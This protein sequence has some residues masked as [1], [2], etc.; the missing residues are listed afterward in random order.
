MNSLDWFLK[1]GG[2]PANTGIPYMPVGNSYLL[3]ISKDVGTKD[4]YP[5]ISDLI[6][7][8][9]ATSGVRLEELLLG[10]TQALRQI[11]TSVSEGQDERI[12]CICLFVDE[13]SDSISEKL[14]PRPEFEKMSKGEDA[15]AWFIQYLAN[16]SLKSGSQVKIPNLITIDTEVPRFG[17]RSSLTGKPTPD[18]KGLEI[19]HQKLAVLNSK[20]PGSGN[21]ME[22]LKELRNISALNLFNTVPSMSGEPLGAVNVIYLHTLTNLARNLGFEE[23]MRFVRT[24]IQTYVLQDPEDRSTG[25]MDSRT[26][27]QRPGIL[28]ACLDEDIV[29]NAEMRIAE[30]FFDGVITFNRAESSDRSRLEISYEIT[31]FPLIGSGLLAEDDYNKNTKE[32]NTKRFLISPDYSKQYRYTPRAVSGALKI[33]G[34]EKPNKQNAAQEA[35]VQISKLAGEQK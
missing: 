16:Q 18:T 11:E 32:A 14:M 29:S 6:F 7:R 28:V 10:K 24:M 20:V 35:K 31:R 33:V 9:T 5:W 30:T 4:L 17:N 12:N 26:L 27:D 1:F 25:K 21:I 13:A 2:G 8:S 3:K 23:A 22:L 19:H 15:N 34:H